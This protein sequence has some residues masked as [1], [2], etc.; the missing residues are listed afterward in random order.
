[1]QSRGCIACAPTP[2]TR[3]PS[4]PR[5]SLFQVHLCCR[6]GQALILQHVVRAA[7]LELGCDGRRVGVLLLCLVACERAGG[8]GEVCTVNKSVRA[9]APSRPPPGAPC[10]AHAPP[11]PLHPTLPTHPPNDMSLKFLTADA[12]RARLTSSSL[13]LR[14]SSASRSLAS[15]S[16]LGLMSSNGFHSTSAAGAHGRGGG[17]RTR[18]SSRSLSAAAHGRGFADSVAPPPMRSHLRA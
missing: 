7:E 12:L 18:R 16:T 5:P 8:A 4:P 14:A 10:H 9:S 15:R 13:R 2:P 3:P 1:M 6:L 11:P 17:G